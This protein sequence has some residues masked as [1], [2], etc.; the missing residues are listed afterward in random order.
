MTDNREHWEDHV[1]ESE[2]RKFEGALLRWRAKEKK[3]ALGKM[4]RALGKRRQSSRE[5]W[6]GGDRLR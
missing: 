6:K 5:L 2:R 3:E 1:K 4:Q